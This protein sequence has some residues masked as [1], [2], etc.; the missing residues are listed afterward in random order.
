M[1]ETHP[2]FYRQDQT[3]DIPKG[4]HDI[5]K[6]DDAAVDLRTQKARDCTEQHMYM[7]SPAQYAHT[8]PWALLPDQVHL[9]LLSVVD[10]QDGLHARRWASDNQL[11]ASY[12]FGMRKKLVLQVVA[13]PLFDDDIVR[14]LLCWKL[15]LSLRENGSQTYRVIIPRK[16]IDVERFRK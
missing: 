1:R 11:S 4:D 3:E 5:A 16:R 12:F 7:P 13:D 14:I 15:A 6:K 2:V 9:I 10:F 8:W